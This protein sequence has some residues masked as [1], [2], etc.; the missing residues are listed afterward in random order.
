MVSEQ[1]Q[2]YSM[3]VTAYQRFLSMFL[4]E[5]NNENAVLCC[6][7][8]FDFCICYHCGCCILSY[9]YRIALSVTEMETAVGILRE[10]RYRPTKEMCD[11]GN[12]FDGNI[13]FN[14]SGKSAVYSIQ[15]ECG[16][17]VDFD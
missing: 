2:K 15:I 5:N 8:N 7:R 14:G 16:K 6:Y 4:S 9:P 17:L 12:Y 11:G 13:N 1:I 10:Q 3:A